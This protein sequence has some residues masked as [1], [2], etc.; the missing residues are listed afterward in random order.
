MYINEIDI[1]ERLAELWR[2]VYAA[3]VHII[4]QFFVRNFW[5][6]LQEDCSPYSVL[7]TAD[8]VLLL[9]YNDG[10]A[11]EAEQFDDTVLYSVYNALLQMREV[12]KL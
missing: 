9:R 12:S 4:D 8:G 1:D 6:A 10:V 5:V 7:L 11:S 3:V 2:D